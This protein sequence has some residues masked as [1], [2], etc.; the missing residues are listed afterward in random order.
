MHIEPGVLSGLK[1]AYANQTALATTAAFAPALLRKP[2]EIIRTIVAA[3][4]FSLLMQL[5]H[6][7]VGASELHLI[8]ASTIYALFGFLPTLLGF[9][10]GLLLQGLVF[11][12]ADLMHLG[13]NSL[14]LMLPLLTAHAL[15]GRGWMQRK[16]NQKHPIH[17]SEVVRFDAIYY[18][19]VVAMVGFWLLNGTE[20]TP[21]AQWGWFAAAYLPLVLLEPVLTLV[22]VRLIKQSP[23]GSWLH[24]WSAVDRL[25]LG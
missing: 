4:F 16:A 18:S 21:L 17:W 9:P 8:G 2:T 23:Q 25:Q 14:S 19:G 13:V 6:Q 1:L 7:S 20:Q 3:L 11:E 24:Q 10:L 22:L 15:I 12:P 5:V